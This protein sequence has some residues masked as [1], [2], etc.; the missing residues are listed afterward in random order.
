M[1]KGIT[2]VKM[3]NKFEDNQSIDIRFDYFLSE[4]AILGDEDVTVTET[5]RHIARQ[6]SKEMESINLNKSEMA[7]R[8]HTSR[9]SLNRLLNENDPSLTLSTLV[10]AA[11]ALGKKVKV[12]LV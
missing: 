12:E 10:N 6:I 3:S 5:K 11:T 2:V 8:M 7:R 4:G 1:I 9:P